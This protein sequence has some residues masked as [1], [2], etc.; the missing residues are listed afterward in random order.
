MYKNACL[1]NACDLEC[2]W[3]I[4]WL[5]FIKHV[6]I[7][8]ENHPFGGIVS[9]LFKNLLKSFEK[10]LNGILVDDIV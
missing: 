2:L 7:F 1:L 6:K 3:T 9:A 4:Y 5:K 8:S 10:N